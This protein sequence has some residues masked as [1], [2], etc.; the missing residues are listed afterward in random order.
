MKTLLCVLL[1]GIVL[2]ALTGCD[3]WALLERFLPGY[4][5]LYYYPGESCC[6]Y[7]V[8][9]YEQEQFR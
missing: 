8:E 6:D 2:A 7:V 9:T 1:I 3:E 4:G 5:E